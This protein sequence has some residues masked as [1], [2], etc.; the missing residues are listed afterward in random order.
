MPEH[1]RFQYEP[2]IGL[3]SVSVVHS[4]SHKKITEQYVYSEVY[5]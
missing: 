3:N 4:D 5:S 2:Y 1:S